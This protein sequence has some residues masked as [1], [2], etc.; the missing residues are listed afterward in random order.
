MTFFAKTFNELSNT[1]LYEILKSRCEIFTVE[2]SILYQD[3]DDVD[4]VSLHCFFVEGERV[5]GYLRAFR[6]DGTE[7]HIGRVLTLDHG[8]GTGRMLIEKSLPIIKEHFGSDLLALNSQTH[9]IGFYEKF[10]FRTASEEFLDAGIPHV[11]MEM[12]I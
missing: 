11:K 12:M 5:V 4:K 3:M 8:K 7:T 10:G 2:Q 6:G 9:A 1:E